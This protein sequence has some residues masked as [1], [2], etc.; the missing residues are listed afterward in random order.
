MTEYKMSEDLE[1]DA[2]VRMYA[3]ALDTIHEFSLQNDESVASRMIRKRVLGEKKEEFAQLLKAHT[4]KKVA[5]AYDNGY[6]KGY[7]E[8]HRD[9]RDGNN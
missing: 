5:E 8:G 4:A 3:G 6:G 2:I 1:L 9:S 7:E